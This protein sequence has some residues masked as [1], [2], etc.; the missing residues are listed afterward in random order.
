MHLSV[1][2][3]ASCV[4]DFVCNRDKVRDDLEHSSNAC[5]FS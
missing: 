5:H 3:S 1:V 2:F 4:L